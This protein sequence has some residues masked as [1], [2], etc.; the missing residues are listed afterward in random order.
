MKSLREHR[1][2]QMLSLRELARRAGV[3]HLTV[4]SIELGRRRHPE[5]RTI[6]KLSVALGVAPEEIRE[7]SDALD[8]RA[9]IYGEAA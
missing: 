4:M 9:R 1:V 5:Y 7:F 8:A 6:T 3:T 2:G